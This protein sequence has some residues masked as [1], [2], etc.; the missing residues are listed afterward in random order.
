MRLILSK[1]QNEDGSW[2]RPVRVEMP[3][4]VSR[5]WNLSIGTHKPLLVPSP[6]VPPGD[7]AVGHNELLDPFEMNIG[8]ENFETA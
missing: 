4:G 7:L 6:I 8:G 2:F 3:T 1:R 5:A